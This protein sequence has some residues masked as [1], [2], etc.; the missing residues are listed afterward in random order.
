MN[1]IIE[2]FAQHWVVQ[3]SATQLNSRC[4]RVYIADPA[5]LDT[6]MRSGKEHSNVVSL[7]NILKRMVN[8]Q[9]QTFGFL[10]TTGE[11]VHDSVDLTQT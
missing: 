2:L 1:N 6:I 11:V 10:R 7:K 3:E 8:L 4:A 5:R 9:S